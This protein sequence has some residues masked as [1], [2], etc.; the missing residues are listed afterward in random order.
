MARSIES[1]REQ[2]IDNIKQTVSRLQA[3][4]DF[5]STDIIAG[6]IT[7]QKLEYV[8]ASEIKRLEREFKALYKIL[9]KFEGL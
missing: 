5:G 1:L 8:F 7:G 3:R 9:P 6:K 4:L 2:R